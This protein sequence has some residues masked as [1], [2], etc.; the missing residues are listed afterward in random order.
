MSY[1]VIKFVM[2]ALIT[3]RRRLLF[4]L[5]F[6]THFPLPRN[7]YRAEPQD[8][9]LWDIFEDPPAKKTTGSADL[10]RGMEI[11]LKL[12]KVCAYIVVL[13]IVLAGAVVSKLSFIFMT[14]Q[15]TVRNVSYCN[16]TG[17]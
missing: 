11:F 14:S 7:D 3:R 5:L 8:T 17:E 2:D 6:L 13:V 4:L 16:D 9:K 15:L 1:S 12:A 10:T